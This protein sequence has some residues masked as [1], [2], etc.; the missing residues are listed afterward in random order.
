[1]QAALWH[2]PHVVI[3]ITQADV[4][5]IAETVE[6]LPDNFDPLAWLEQNRIDLG[7]VVSEAVKD[8]IFD[9]LEVGL[10]DHPLVLRRH[11]DCC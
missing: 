4:S 9:A 7:I 10:V 8:V 11:M 1:M 6:S 5:E 2:R 3:I